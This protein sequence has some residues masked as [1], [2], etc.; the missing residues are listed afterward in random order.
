MSV[1]LTSEQEPSQPDSAETGGGEKNKQ[2][3]KTS[4]V[5][6]TSSDKQ[7]TTHIICGEKNRIQFKVRTVKCSL[8]EYIQL[9]R[10]AIP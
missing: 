10:K 4:R 2:I 3:S 6:G 5:S 7:I 1:L 8:I 9:S